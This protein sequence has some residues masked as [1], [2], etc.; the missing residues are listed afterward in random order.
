MLVL[1]TDVA[2]AVAMGSDRGKLFRS[3]INGSSHVIGSEYLIAESTHVIRKCIGGNLIEAKDG[4]KLL[5]KIDKMIDTFYPIQP[6]AN[7]ALHESIRLNH[8]PYDMF[9]FIL[10]RRYGATIVSCDQKLI[11]LC[12]KEGL[13]VCTEVPLK[14]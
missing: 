7:E 4:S 6:D 12:V 13:D 8:S 11:D 3:F 2:V 9:N 5:R 14:N 1:D 10:A